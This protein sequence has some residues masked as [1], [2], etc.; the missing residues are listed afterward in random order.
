MLD[1]AKSSIHR[2]PGGG[3]RLPL[4]ICAAQRDKILSVGILADSG[5]E[6]AAFDLLTHAA[7]YKP[8]LREADSVGQHWG[9]PGF[10]LPCFT[11]RKKFWYAASR[12][13]SAACSAVE[14]ASLSQFNSCFSVVNVLSC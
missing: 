8:E 9:K 7:S 14:S 4:H 6:N 13:C 1:G 10:S 5:G 12:F 11:R 2:R 3:Q